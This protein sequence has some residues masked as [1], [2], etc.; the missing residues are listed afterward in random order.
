MRSSY[1][2][3]KTSLQ[4]SK[5]LQNVCVG[6]KGEECAYDQIDLN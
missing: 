5:Y 3:N 4:Q 6:V 2:V 1:N